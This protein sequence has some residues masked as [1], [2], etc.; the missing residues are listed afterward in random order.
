VSSFRIATQNEGSVELKRPAADKEKAAELP[1][2]L[3]SFSSSI[4][5]L[6][7]LSAISWLMMFRSVREM[8]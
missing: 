4:G 3:Q 7:V 8:T 1:S 6:F 5:G 2:R